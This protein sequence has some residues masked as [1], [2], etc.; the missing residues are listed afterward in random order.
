MTENNNE[1]QPIQRRRSRSFFWPVL[2]I[3]AGI[4]FLLSNLGIVNWNTWNLLWRFWPL[5]LIAV[6]IDV[7]FGHRSAVGSIISAFLILALIGAAAVTIFFAEQIPFINRFQQESPWNSDHIEAE[8]EKYD[9]AMVHIDWASPPGYLGVLD[10][11]DLLIAGDLTYQ[12]ELIFNV[13]SKGSQAEINLDTR[14][15]NN[16]VP[17][18]FQSNPKAEWDIYLTPDIPLDLTLDSGSGSCEFDLSELLLDD[19]FLDSGSGS[20]NLI[21]PE[22]Q[23]Y[24]VKIDSGSGSIRIDIPEDTGIRVRID[25]GSGSFNPGNAFSLESGERRGDG[26]WESDNFDTA[27]FTIEMQ[28]DQGSGSI[29]F[30]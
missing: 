21:L 28:I 29:S 22:D 8:L 17:F 10:D 27:K 7:L 4:L 23:S 5:V 20:I 13:D 16:W 3:S 12:G 6:G 14:V 11:P 1:I 25:S 2:L 15:V 30:K 26:T 18:S 9:S 19:F 24:P